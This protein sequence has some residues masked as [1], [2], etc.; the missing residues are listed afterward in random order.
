MRDE[1]PGELGGPG[2]ADLRRRLGVL[3]PHDRLRLEPGSGRTSNQAEY[4]GDRIS[5]FADGGGQIQLRTQ[6]NLITD[7][8]SW[9]RGHC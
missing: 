3:A 9:G 7:C 4:L 1:R 8:A 5:G 6:T 2:L